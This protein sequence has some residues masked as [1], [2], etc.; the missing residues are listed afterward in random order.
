MQCSTSH[1]HE[2]RWP[3]DSS[4]TIELKPLWHNRH[5]ITF[6]TLLQAQEFMGFCGLSNPVGS[7]S[8]APSPVPAQKPLLSPSRPM[9]G[10]LPHLRRAEF[11]AYLQAILLQSYCPGPYSLKGWATHVSPVGAFA[12]SPRATVSCIAQMEVRAYTI[13]IRKHKLV[14]IIHM[15]VFVY[16]NKSVGCVWLLCDSCTRWKTLNLRCVVIPSS[17]CGY[18]PALYLRTSSV[19]TR[20]Y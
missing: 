8:A 6:T 10:S 2:W 20:K 3:Y 14:C 9:W 5:I 11:L 15:P 12:Q 19:R 7:G 17:A 16:V 13:R 1:A 4:E 18:K